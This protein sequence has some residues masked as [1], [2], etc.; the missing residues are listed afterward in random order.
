MPGLEGKGGR[1]WYGQDGPGCQVENA[2]SSSG[3][4]PHEE[5]GGTNGDQARSPAGVR[6]ALWRMREI[7]C[8]LRARSIPSA[9]TLCQTHPGPDPPRNEAT[10]GQTHGG[11]DPRRARPT[12]GR[13]KLGR[14]QT[15]PEPNWESGIQRGWSVG[16]CQRQVKTVPRRGGQ[17]RSQT[18]SSESL[19]SRETGRSQLIATW[20]I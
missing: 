8:W 19:A 18:L 1:A 5:G 14:S 10:P 6:T 17:Y 12:P 15:G 2:S 7:F 3:T 16:A 13:A 11:P 9:A 20:H 4:H